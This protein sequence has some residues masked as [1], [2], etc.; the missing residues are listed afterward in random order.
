M[1]HYDCDDVQR[2]RDEARLRAVRLQDQTLDGYWRALAA[3][4]RRWMSRPLRSREAATPRR[5]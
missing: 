3:W 2:I 5:A 4:S 1:H